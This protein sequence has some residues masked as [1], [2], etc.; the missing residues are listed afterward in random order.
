MRAAI[1][2][3]CL[4]LVHGLECRRAVPRQCGRGRRLEP[5]CLTRFCGPAA[6]AV[7]SFLPR[8]PGSWKVRVKA[9]CPL[10]RGASRLVSLGFSSGEAERGRK[11]SVTPSWGRWSC[12]LRPCVTVIIS[13][14]LS[15]NPASLGSRPRLSGEGRVQPQHGVTV[16]SGSGCWH[17]KGC[18]SLEGAV[19]ALSKYLGSS[20]ALSVLLPRLKQPRK[21]F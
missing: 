4:L 14:G 1:C 12:G 15:P 17:R 21:L 20:P 7:C 19:S 18:R 3:R 8:G 9:C 16:R 5:G 13:S 11:P 2:R 6:W 10:P